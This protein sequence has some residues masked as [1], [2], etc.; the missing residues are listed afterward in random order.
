MRI[1]ILCKPESGR[2]GERTL[3]NVREALQELGVEAE[4]H[5]YRD[6]RKMIDN[7]VYVSPAL[8]IDDNVRIAGRAPEVK[9]IAGLL[10]ERPRDL[11]RLEEGA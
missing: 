11:K 5:L 9:E 1:D 7:R 3:A 2:R 8:L 6:R 4:V 10:I